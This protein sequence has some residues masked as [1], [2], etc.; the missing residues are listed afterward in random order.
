M[1]DRVYDNRKIGVVNF[2]YLEQEAGLPWIK[3][4]GLIS[5]P[6][7]GLSAWVR[8]YSTKGMRENFVSL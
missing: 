5:W 1:T 4:F 8:P 7:H 3:K 2:T 6:T